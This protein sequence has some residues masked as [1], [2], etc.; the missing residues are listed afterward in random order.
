MIS[1]TSPTIGSTARPPLLL[2]L[3][4]EVAV[5][6]TSTM[7]LFQ[8]RV[9]S[10]MSPKD[11]QCLDMIHR[12]CY[13]GDQEAIC[14][15]SPLLQGH[16]A[17]FILLLRLV[18]VS[19]MQ[20]S[21]LRQEHLSSIENQLSTTEGELE[22]TA[23]VCP[24]LHHTVHSW[25][26]M[27]R[28]VTIVLRIYLTALQQ[29]DFC[30]NSPQI[31]ALATRGL[32]EAR[33]IWTLTDRGAFTWPSPFAAS[34]TRASRNIAGCTIAFILACALNDSQALEEIQARL[35]NAQGCLSA[36]HYEN[37]AQVLETLLRRSGDKEG[38]VSC[39]A[40]STVTCQRRHDGLD[41]L[42]L[43]RGP[44]EIFDLDR[45]GGV[46]SPETRNH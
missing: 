23:L 37:L 35:R 14:S 30:S 25:T 18:H 9:L 31:S 24:D 32:H 27:W 33:E 39:P 41:L 26:T 21:A 19:R 11:W 7:A 4:F 3:A 29:P 45:V 28:Y 43:S 13:E 34:K 38:S 1:S 17:L 40:G 20:P 46:G 2:K 36:S 16:A 12:R 8:R 6:G 15:A 42:R 22:T 5:L 10:H 44:F